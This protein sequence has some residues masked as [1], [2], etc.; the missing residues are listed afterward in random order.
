MLSFVLLGVLGS[1]LM[2]PTES[3]IPKQSVLHCGQKGKWG[4]DEQGAC[5]KYEKREARSRP[6]ESGELRDREVRQHGAASGSSP[7]VAGQGKR[8]GSLRKGVARR[9]IHQD[10]EL[11]DR[12]GGTE[13]GLQVIGGQCVFFL[14]R[15]SEKS[16]SGSAQ[17]K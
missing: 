7:G 12:L 1:L 5:S 2:P 9:E 16:K 15:L 10:V 4:S 6:G 17:G 11:R 8:K 13:E 14:H 3:G